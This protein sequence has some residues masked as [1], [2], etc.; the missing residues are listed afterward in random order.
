MMKFLRIILFMLLMIMPT[1]LTAKET[2]HQV[3]GAVVDAFTYDRLSYAK[4]DLLRTDSSLI[5]SFITQSDSTD[6]DHSG[7][8]FFEI[9]KKGS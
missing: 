4:V 3:N 1:V 7:F 8:F 5:S 9:T 2:S 6:S